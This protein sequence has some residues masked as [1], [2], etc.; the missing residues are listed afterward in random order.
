MIPIVLECLNLLILCFQKNS[1]IHLQNISTNTDEG[2]MDLTFW[3]RP[4][5]KQKHSGSWAG[6]DWH[7]SYKSLH[8][9]CITRSFSAAKISMKTENETEPLRGGKISISNWSLLQGLSM[10]MHPKQY[11]KLLTC[12][13][14]IFCTPLLIA[15]ISRWTLSDAFIKHSWEMIVWSHKW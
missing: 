11:L 12:I 5:P 2:R 9:L 15:W 13:S 3:E 1:K 14:M 6:S 10:N 8:L 7:D 4:F